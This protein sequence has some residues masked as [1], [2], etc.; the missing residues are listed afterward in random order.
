MTAIEVGQVWNN[1]FQGKPSTI[2]EL[3]IKD[4]T[5]YITYRAEEPEYHDGP[6]IRTIDEE[7]F[8]WLYKRAS[9]PTEHVKR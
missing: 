5:L 1:K 9:E 7:M 6:D 3:E 8:L 2:V 4:D